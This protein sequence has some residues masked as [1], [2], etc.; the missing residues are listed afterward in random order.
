[1]K[2]TVKMSCGLEE[3]VDLFGPG[4]ERERRIQYYETQGLCKECYLK[5]KREAEK[6][7]GL[8]FCYFYTSEIDKETGSPLAVVWFFGDTMPHK[9]QIKE[10]GYRWSDITSFV[11]HFCDCRM[12]WSLF[13]DEDLLNTK[14]DQAKSIGATIIDPKA[15]GPDACAISEWNYRMAL[16]EQIHWKEIAEKKAAIPKPQ[17]PEIL[18]GHYWNKKIYGKSGNRS[19]YLDGE[20]VEISDE[21]VSGIEVYLKD[22]DEYNKLLSQIET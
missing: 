16:K 12:A 8:Q 11:G 1:M 22:R 7:A 15:L 13:V 6:A 5:Q 20:K 18:K 4:K 9:D 10:L 14:I 19:I 3:V 21:Q 17:I 2:Y